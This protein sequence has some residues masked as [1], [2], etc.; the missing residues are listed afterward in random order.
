MAVMATITQRPSGVWE[1]RRRVPDRLRGHLGITEVRQSLDTKDK[2]VAKVRVVAVIA[3]VERRFAAAGQV[4]TLDH[5]SVVALAARW[6]ASRVAADEASP[7]DAETIDRNLGALQ[8]RSEGYGPGAIASMS[9]TVDELLIAHDLPNVDQ[10]SRD[11]LAVALFW[12]SVT[13][14]QTLSRRLSGDYGP[15]PGLANA[16]PWVSPVAPAGTRGEDAPLTLP[17]LF[18]AWAAERKPVQKT[19]D[20]FRSCVLKFCAF[21]GHEDATR[22]T[23]TDVVNW[24]DALVQSG[25]KAATINNKQLS[26]LKLALGYGKDNRKLPAN[27]ATGVSVLVPRA[28][29]PDMRGYT[30]AE[31]RT[32]L[33]A[34][35]AL[36]GW[37]RWLPFL[38]A[39]TGTRI[40][41][42]ADAAAADVKQSEDGVWCIDMTD[43]VLKNDSSARAIPLH[44][45]LIAEGFLEYVQGLP[46]GGPLFPDLKP[47]KTYGKRG[48]RASKVVSRWVRMSLGITDKRIGP[49]HAWRHRM[50]TLHRAARIPRDASR[51]LRGY[52]PEDDADDYG[53]HNLAALAEYMGSIPP[54]A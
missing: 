15:V 4:V 45:A 40:S 11:A 28:D 18:D 29:R 54:M 46:A 38:S 1:Y 41:E 26:A 7:P 17:A 33:T 20:S 47:G 31:A 5:R 2:A 43:R 9:S 50:A 12:H 8:D 32:I 25:L 49:N 23:D 37:R 52:S 30:D 22:V 14:W 10:V 19:V 21:I 53:T 34:A 16:P 51:Y 44:P 48:D 35:R 42:P 39:Y 6:L 36:T 24:K 3:D 27:V 13:Y